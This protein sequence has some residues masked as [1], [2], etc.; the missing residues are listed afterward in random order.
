MVLGREKSS[1]AAINGQSGVDGWNRGE[2]EPGITQSL[3]LPSRRKRGPAASKVDHHGCD[4]HSGTTKMTRALHLA[5]C[6]RVREMSDHSGTHQFDSFDQ[7]WVKASVASARGSKK[8]ELKRAHTVLRELAKRSIV[9][10]PKC[11]QM[12]ATVSFES[13]QSSRSVARERASAYA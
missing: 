8:R 7:S 5:A 11:A 4:G 6:R 13:R 12:M 1:E 10:R 2:R 3:R 9:G